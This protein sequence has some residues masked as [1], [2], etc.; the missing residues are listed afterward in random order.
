MANAQKRHELQKKNAAQAAARKK[1][2]KGATS[3]P[4]VDETSAPVVDETPAPVVVVEIAA[5]VD[6]LTGAVGADPDAEP[7]ETTTPAPTVRGTIAAA[8]DAKVPTPIP[9]VLGIAERY[10]DLPAEAGLLL[11]RADYIASCKPRR[12]DWTK[13]EA[14]VIRKAAAMTEA[15]KTL[16]NTVARPE[17]EKAATGGRAATAR[18]ESGLPD[19]NDPEVQ[20]ALADFERFDKIKRKDRTPEQQK[21]WAV[22]YRILL[23]E[24]KAS[25]DYTP[26]GGRGVAPG[27]STGTGAAPRTG[28]VV[29][30]WLPITE[31]DPICGHEGCMR[32]TACRVVRPDLRTVADRCI[33]H[34]L[35]LAQE[36]REKGAPALL[37]YPDN[38]LPDIMRPKKKAAPETPAAESTADT[39]PA[40]A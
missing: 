25:E 11:T 19:R 39:T 10:K 16:G 4:V 35:A 32:A 1:K 14:R 34:G 30:M 5:A 23:R 17:R 38:T 2:G 18:T 33:R 21:L 22:G 6:P 13:D 40:A 29:S 8:P 36:L 3:A 20:Q 12:S 28:R 37:T 31:P 24:R 15:L 7:E 27:E 9:A 26:R